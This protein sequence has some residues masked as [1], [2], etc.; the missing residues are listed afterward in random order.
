MTPSITIDHVRALM[1]RTPNSVLWDRTSSDVT[2]AAP[3]SAYSLISS[4]RCRY[5]CSRTDL[6]DSEVHR[7]NSGSLAAGS[8][9]RAHEVVDALNDLVAET[10]E[11]SH[12]VERPPGS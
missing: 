5:L 4:G 6:Q 12:S 1:A 11:A 3:E 7:D 2:L 10:P 8:L 9:A